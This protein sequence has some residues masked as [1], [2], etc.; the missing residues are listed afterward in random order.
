MCKQSE[1]TPHDIKDINIA[2][3][4]A[5]CIVVHSEVAPL[6]GSK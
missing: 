5:I 2:L 4:S 3:E 6:Y 1:I